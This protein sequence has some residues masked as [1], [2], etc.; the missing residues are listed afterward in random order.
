M[1]KVKWNGEKLVYERFLPRRDEDTKNVIR[2]PFSVARLN[3]IRAPGSKIRRPR[4]DARNPD[5]GS[6]ITSFLLHFSFFIFDTA[7]AI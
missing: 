2:D 6:R 5:I 3:G 1:P 4:P 7:A